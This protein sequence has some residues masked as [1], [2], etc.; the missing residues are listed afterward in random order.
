MSL[1][2]IAIIAS[3]VV[4]LIAIVTFGAKVDS[5]WARAK[6]MQMMQQSLEQLEFRLDRKIQSDK[7]YELQRR[8][9]N[10]EDRYG[11]AENMPPEVRDEYRILKSEIEQIKKEMEKDPNN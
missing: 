6:D 5:R 1:K 9:W 2:K 3:L 7:L 10:F 8:I 11:D 4:S